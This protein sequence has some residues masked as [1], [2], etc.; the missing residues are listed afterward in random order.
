LEEVFQHQEKYE[1]QSNAKKDHSKDGTTF[2]A[3]VGTYLESL[4]GT[5]TSSDSHGARK[6][7]LFAVSI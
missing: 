5:T 6:V 2:F 7:F 3:L 1:K 4:A